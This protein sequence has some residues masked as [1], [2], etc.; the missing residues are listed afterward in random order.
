MADLGGRIVMGLAWA[1]L[2]IVGWIT[3]MSGGFICVMV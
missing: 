2:E 3:R 1:I